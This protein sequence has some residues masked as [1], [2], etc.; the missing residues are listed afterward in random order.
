VHTLI[1]TVTEAPLQEVA[2]ATEGRAADFGLDRPRVR[3]QLESPAAVVRVALG[4]RNPPQT[5]VYAQV[6]DN[7]QVVLIGLNV[8]YYVDLLLANV[9]PPAA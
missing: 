2:G 8:E 9:A 6:Q 1:A 5:A 7:P 4:A 3:V